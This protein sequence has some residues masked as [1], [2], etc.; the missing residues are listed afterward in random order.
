MAN[1]H[2]SRSIALQ[3]LF[4]WDFNGMN[5]LTLRSIVKRNL[6]EFAPGI[7]ETIF[8]DELVDGIISKQAKL[9]SIIEKAAPDWPIE[10]IAF[11]DRNVLRLGLYELLFADRKE[12]PARVAINEAIELAKTFGGENSGRFV[13]GVLG[14]IYKELGEP[15][16]DEVPAKKRRVADVPY[17]QMP[18]EK[19][20]GAVVYTRDG[21][22]L[23]LALVHDMFGYWTLSKGKIGDAPAIAEESTEEG[24]KREVKEE[25][26]LDIVIK[27]DL[28][29]NEYVASHPEKGKIRKQVH[30]YLAEVKDKN[31]LKLTKQEGLNDTKWFPLEEIPDLRMYDDIVPIVT[32][33][34]KLL[35]DKGNNNF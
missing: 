20:G 8:V 29:K 14:T 11:V 10:K 18:V 33:A 27:S 21:G 6:E 22:K 34:V 1:R 13:N 15:G 24:T 4:E 5:N 25:I 17:E 2:L 19:L 31:Q 23:A 26:S 9:D 3:S 7:E 32:R 28:G 12:V 30:Y 16:K 35:L